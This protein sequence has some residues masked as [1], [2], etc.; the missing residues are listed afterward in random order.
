MNNLP[1][2]VLVL[3]DGAG[4]PFGHL[5]LAPADDAPKGEC[6]FDIAPATPE[7]A[8][9]NE[10]RWLAKRGFQRLGEHRFRAEPSGSITVVL[11]DWTLALDPVDEGHLR[12]RPPAPY[13]TAVWGSP[14]S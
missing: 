11:G 14:S 6:V 1:S 4:T 2:H 5:R 3:S 7:Q 12:S 8:L 10:V 9:R 13:V